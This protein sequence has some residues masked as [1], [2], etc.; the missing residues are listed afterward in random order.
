MVD[1]LEPQEPYTMQEAMRTIKIELYTRWTNEI[2]QTELKRLRLVV[3]NGK[4][5]P[6]VRS[7]MLNF[8]SNQLLSGHGGFN[9]FLYKIRK[10]ETE[11]C[12]FGD[13]RESPEHILL[14][15]CGY[16]ELRLQ[17]KLSSADLDVCNWPTTDP[18]TATNV[19][20]FA[21]LAFKSRAIMVH[22]QAQ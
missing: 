2:E 14:D 22:C 20:V 9:S 4:I 5:A 6:V 16:N 3:L 13:G 12:P 21:E 11:D 8:Y 15:C 10:S 19:A 17:L 18:N 7:H 1:E